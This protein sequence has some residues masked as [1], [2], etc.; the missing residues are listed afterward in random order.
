MNDTTP[1][2]TEARPARLY[3]LDWLRV[4]AMLAIFSFHSDRPFNFDDWHVKNAATNLFSSLH[5]SFFDQWMMP[6]FFIISGA[7]VYYSLKSR[8]PG[9]F[10]WERVLRIAVPW[11]ILGIFV[12]APPQVYLDRLTH[13]DFSGSFLQCVEVKKSLGE[14][15]LKKMLWLLPFGRSSA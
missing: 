7:A 15:Y 4:L 10:A 12:M 5:V 1:R 8:R 6:L 9:G 14:Q 13:G 3:Y 2:A 11:L